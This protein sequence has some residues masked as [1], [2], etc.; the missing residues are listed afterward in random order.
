M[1]DEADVK[2]DDQPATPSTPGRRVMLAGVGIVTLTSLLGFATMVS[3]WLGGSDID[4]KRILR[5]ASSQYVS[6]NRIVAG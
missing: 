6:G 3:I 1:A 2:A 5:L 4:S